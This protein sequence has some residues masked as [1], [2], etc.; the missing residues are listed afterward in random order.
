MK[1]K[2]LIPFIA[3]FLVVCLLPGLLL[4]FGYEAE[5]RENRPL[6]RMPA[7]VGRNGLNLK[8]P[9]EF[10]AYFEDHFGLREEMV[11]AFHGFTM[12]TTA[13]TFN[14]KTIVGKNG[15]LFY[16]ETLAD[17]LKTEPLCYVDLL[18]IGSSLR[19]QKEYLEHQGINFAFSIAPNKNTIYPEYM[20]DRYRPIA[21][22]SNREGLYEVL[23]EM[24]IRTID[25]AGNLLSRKDEGQLYHDQDTHWNQR[26]ALIGYRAIMELVAEG[27]S[28]ETYA[29][30][31]P[32][33]IYDDGG[34]LHNFLL[35]AV[36]G[37]RPR[38]EYRITTDYAFDEGARPQ[39]DAV[40]G[41]TSEANDAS[42]YLFRD[43]FAIALQPYLSGNLGRVVF[44]SSFP[45]SYLK[46]Q[47]EQPDWVV[48]ELVE[49]NIKNL[50]L[51]APLMPALEVQAPTQLQKANGEIELLAASHKQNGYLRLYGCY[52]G[53][54]MG[55]ELYVLLQ[56]GETS[57]CFKAF[58]ILEENAEALAE[59]MAAPQGFSLTLPE[60]F[61]G[62]WELSVLAGDQVTRTMQIKLK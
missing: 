42:L 59:T 31:T 6:A 43:S 48:I 19:L 12:A 13:D 53:S 14:D 56:N 32:E 7:L 20:P 10:D 23:G 47:E 34:D 26:G 36:D 61:S 25:F 29:D 35:P 57:H 17:Y 58:P 60:E 24:G 2:R 52:D 16:Q 11:T 21:E 1:Q 55:E 44:D 22:Q 8:F 38:P 18:R 45:Y 50:L 27:Q 54:Y 46:V 62:N 40:F 3:F 5:N 30:I 28:Y 51:S 15:M 9:Q 41:T 33:T 37:K 49:R 39:Q 4:L